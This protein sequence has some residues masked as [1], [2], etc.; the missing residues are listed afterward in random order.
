MSVHFLS[1]RSRLRR[2]SYLLLGSVLTA[3]TGAPAS[4]APDLAQNT[5][6]MG[7]NAPP[8]DLL[9]AHAPL[10]VLHPSDVTLVYPLPPAA[11]IDKMVW[12]NTYARHGRLVPFAAFSQIQRPLDPRE[13]S[14]TRE[15]GNTAWLNL[16][17]VAVRLDPCAGSRGDIPEAECRGQ[18]RL[19][20]QGVHGVEGR[21]GGDDGAVHVLYDVPRAELRTFAQELLDLT[22]REGGIDAAPLGVHPILKRQGV[23]GRFGQGLKA[24]LLTHL[25]E[26]RATRLTFFSRTDAVPSAWRLGILDRLGS[27]FAPQTIVTTQTGEQQLQLRIAAAGDIEAVTPTPTTHADNLTL[28]LSATVARASD[29]A[30]R[31]KA[32]TAALRIENPRIHTPDTIDCLSC[33]VAMATRVFAELRLGMSTEGNPDRFTS[34]QDLRFD[35]PPQPSLENIHALSYLEDELGISQRAANESAAVA[36]AMT[37]FMKQE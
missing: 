15:T 16:R 21:S 10:R 13:T 24:L 30:A 32:L 29:T 23:W 34:T 33:H 37:E 11:D 2:L 18:V 28:L 26:N 4:G 31:Q 8:A 5:P 20:F 3:C 19:V 14:R 7:Q 17:L 35:M 36:E 9:P 6:D 1:G 25:G 27:G 12:G 22:E